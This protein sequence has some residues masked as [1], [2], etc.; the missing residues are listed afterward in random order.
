MYLTSKAIVFMN[1]AA[2]LLDDPRLLAC[3]GTHLHVHKRLCA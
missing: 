3:A 2:W 1:M